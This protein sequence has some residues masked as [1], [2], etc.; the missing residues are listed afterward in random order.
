[1]NA[2]EQLVDNLM[3]TSSQL[4][5]FHGEV[6]MQLFLNDELKLPSIVEICVER[7]R[8]SDI[9]KVIPQYDNTTIM[10]IFV[11]DV[12]NDEWIF[13]LDP[14]IRI[15]KSNIYFHSLNWDVDYIKPEIVLMYDLM[16]HHQYHHYSNYKRVIDALSYYQF[17]ILKF[18]VGEQRIKDAI[19][20]TINN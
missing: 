3:K 19:Q 2:K 15:P 13:R 1:M 16:Q 10:S 5:K 4:F 11:Y 8:L 7:K 17:F 14:N 18:V 20:R 6:A 12:V 9:V